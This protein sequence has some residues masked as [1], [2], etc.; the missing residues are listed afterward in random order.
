MSTKTRTSLLILAGL[1]LVSGWFFW[2]RALGTARDA[3][4]P[5]PTPRVAT[6][7]T[8]RNEQAE[9]FATTQTPEA[10][11]SEIANLERA[12]AKLP[13]AEAAAALVDLLDAGVDG[14]TGLAFRVGP[15]G[16]LVSAP[17][18]RVWMLHR[19]GQ[20]D[21]LLA[22]A[23]AEEI[24]ATGNSPD[25]W[26]VALRNQWREAAPL[27]EM[28]AV[29]ERVLEMMH[30]DEWAESPSAGFLEGL[31]LAVASV[32]WEA[33]PRLEEWLAPGQPT[34][35]RAAA[36]LT[37]DRMVLEAPQ[38]TLAQYAGHPNWLASQPMLR[39]G[40]MARANVENPSE[41]AVVET[42][43]R[44]DIPSAEGQRFFELL[45]NVSTALSHN[46]ATPPHV[47]SAWTA[48]QRDRATLAVVQG[49]RTSSA[50]ARWESD[51]AAAEERLAESVAS[52]KRGGYLT[53]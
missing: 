46:L 29:R 31:D 20:L 44:R 2:P 28:A 34:A 6:Q 35:L 5:T 19:L 27:G 32:A 3:S 51:L 14:R 41:R 13:P 49:W 52:A 21:R 33:V 1:C 23:Y 30:R 12:L 11:R 24:F 16:A 26:S 15:G 43:L 39:A 10:L 45:P 42:Y 38:D 7:A 40:V 48:A 50:F 53:P 37:L 8:P 36:W 17:T 47:V 25:E 22:A 18:L 4:G 9:R